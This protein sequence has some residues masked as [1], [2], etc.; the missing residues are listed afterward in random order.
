MVMVRFAAVGVALASLSTAARAQGTLGAQG[1]GYPPGQLSVYARATGGAM[2]E[3]DALSPLNPAAIAFL[4]RGGLYLQS[5]QENRSLDA[6]GRSGGTRAYRFPLFAAALPVGAR[7]MVAVSF[8]TLLD[9]T[10]GTTT[11]GVAEFGDETVEFTEQF[12][13]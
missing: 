7:A 4:Q 1:F 3:D 10:W 13:A 6:G 8:S 5:E 2:A 9:R 11:R 12:R